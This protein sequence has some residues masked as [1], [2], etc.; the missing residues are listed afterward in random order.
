MA[1]LIEKFSDLFRSQKANSVFIAVDELNNSIIAA[2][3]VTIP[4][5]HIAIIS[6]TNSIILFELE[7]EKFEKFKES[8]L[9]KYAN[10]IDQDKR[11]FL[12]YDIEHNNVIPRQKEKFT[13]DFIQTTF[14]P[15]VERERIP[16]ACE[17]TF[18]K[19]INDRKAWRRSSQLIANPTTSTSD[20]RFSIKGNL[21]YFLLSTNPLTLN[22]TNKNTIKK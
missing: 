4:P 17:I 21:R 6:K 1:S 19:E 16:P 18:E 12:R 3:N 20:K 9:A 5:E 7:D 8:I 14:F 13:I 22:S 15:F 2:E 10:A 11:K